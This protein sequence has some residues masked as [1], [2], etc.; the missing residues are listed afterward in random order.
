MKGNQLPQIISQRHS[1]LTKIR[2]HCW[3]TQRFERLHIS[4]MTPSVTLFDCTEKEET[5]GLELYN[6][7]LQPTPGKRLHSSRPT[8][9]P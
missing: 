4:A 1:T 7:S 9:S 8:L 5:E 3:K 6:S 2:S